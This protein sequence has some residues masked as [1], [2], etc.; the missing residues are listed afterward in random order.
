V[1]RSGPLAAELNGITGAALWI[2]HVVLSMAYL[3]VGDERTGAAILQR[4]VSPAFDR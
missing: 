4:F 3:P 1:R 2:V